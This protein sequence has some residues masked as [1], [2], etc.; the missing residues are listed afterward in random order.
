MVH[1]KRS[2]ALL[3]IKAN[4]TRTEQSWTL[5]WSIPTLSSVIQIPWRRS[6]SRPLSFASS[7]ARRLYYKGTAQ[8]GE[9][10]PSSK[11]S[12]VRG[13]RLCHYEGRGGHLKSTPLI[14]HTHMRCTY[15]MSYSESTKETAHPTLAKKKNS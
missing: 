1:F 7:P 4:L 13:H 3:P 14:H 12:F 5:I 9:M 6:I 15:H 10:R 2:D 8:P 11:F